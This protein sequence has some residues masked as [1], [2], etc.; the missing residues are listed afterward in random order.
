[1]S[2]EE[3]LFGKIDE[4]RAE[5]TRLRSVNAQMLEALK[6]MIDDYTETPMSAA[7]SRKSDAAWDAMTAAIA[8]AEAK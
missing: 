6:G 1:M 8:A 7:E 2:A 4:M 5:I 3:V